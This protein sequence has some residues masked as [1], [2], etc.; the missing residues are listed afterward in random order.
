[1]SRSAVE[2]RAQGAVDEAAPLYSDDRVRITPSWLSIEQTQ[3]AIR[4]VVRLDNKESK[5]RNGIAYL[6]FFAAIPLIAYS[7]YQF[8]NPD[9]P[10]ILPWVM[11]LASAVIWL[12]S[13][14]VVFTTKPRYRL[15][16]TLFNGH[17][18]IV[19]TNSKTAAS[20]MLEAMTQAMDWHRN[21]DIVIEAERASHVRRSMA[22]SNASGSGYEES[23][24][25]MPQGSG[26]QRQQRQQLK[27]LM[28]LLAA[29]LKGRQ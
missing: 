28:P 3:F 11:L 26:Q 21:E 4:T 2:V 7:L 17:E 12:F 6:F 27:K 5:P 16:I 22:S 18:V 23:E 13:A 25:D 19:K 10:A 1:L 29:M 20:S 14:W 8:K 15:R 9:L 24:D